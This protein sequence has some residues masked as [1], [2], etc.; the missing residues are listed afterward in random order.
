MK[1]KYWVVKC[2]T[3]GLI[4]SD[5]LQYFPDFYPNTMSVHKHPAPCCYWVPVSLKLEEKNNV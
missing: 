2:S 5:T 4:D 1:H 3:T